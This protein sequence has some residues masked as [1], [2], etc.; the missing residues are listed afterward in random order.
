MHEA[1][2]TM[3]DSTVTLIINGLTSGDAVREVSESL[4]GVEGVTDVDVDEQ[5]GQA[6]IEVDELEP[7]TREDLIKA[8]EEAGLAVGHIEME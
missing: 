5:S 2:N 1:R 3:S 8:V 6:R 4:L 7:P